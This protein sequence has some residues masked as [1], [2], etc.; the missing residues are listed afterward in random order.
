MKILNINLENDFF[1]FQLKNSLKNKR[2]I[3]F[4]LKNKRLLLHCYLI[5]R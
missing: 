4:N 3:K 2:I 5:D 1:S